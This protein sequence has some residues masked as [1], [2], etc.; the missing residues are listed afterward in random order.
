MLLEN[1]IKKSF[2][3]DYLVGSNYS[4]TK[5][6]EQNIQQITERLED[7]LKA[8]ELEKINKISHKEIAKRVCS[9][10]KSYIKRR[11]SNSKFLPWKEYA[12]LMFKKAFI[13]EIYQERLIKMIHNKFYKKEKIYLKKDYYV[14]KNEI[15]FKKL[16]KDIV[17]AVRRIDR[18]VAEK[19][20]IN[21]SK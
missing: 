19:I 1:D 16:E 8:K 3:L 18:K 10:L 11:H 4:V 20:F 12:Q 21:K 17:K 9:I 14:Y 7:N 5:K 6:I 2:T 15:D 13:P